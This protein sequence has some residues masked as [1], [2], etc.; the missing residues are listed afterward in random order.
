MK[1]LCFLIRVDRYC[2]ICSF[3]LIYRNVDKI[4]ITFYKSALMLNTN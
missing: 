2:D 1:I 4:I 3:Y